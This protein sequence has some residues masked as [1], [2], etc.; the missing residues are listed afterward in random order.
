MKIGIIG[1]SGLYSISGFEFIKDVEVRSVFGKPSSPYKIFKKG[2]V[3]FYFLSRHGVNHTLAPHKVNYRANID[4][5]KQL[6][7][8]Q[9]LSFNAVGGIGRDLKPSD[10]VIPDNAIDMTNGRENTFYEEND[11]VHIDL[12][13]P[14]CEII[15]DKLIDL[16]KD[17]SFK[18]RDKGIYVCTN[19]PRLETAAEIKMYKTLGADIV[20]MTLFPEVTLAREAEICYANVSIVTN[21]AAGISKNKLTTVEVIE[22]IKQSEEKLREILYLYSENIPNTNGCKCTKALEDAGISK[23]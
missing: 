4:G 8:S 3:E 11:I 6:G 20:G 13:Y 16:S 9:I 10:I 22:T 17:F 5:F 12:T 19:G 1:G 21:F 7:V 15:R 18:I 23:K 2:G 14:F